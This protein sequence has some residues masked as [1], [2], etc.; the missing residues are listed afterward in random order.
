MLDPEFRIG[1]QL[2]AGALALA[3]DYIDLLFADHVKE[4]LIGDLN[5]LNGVEVRR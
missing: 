3:T 4:A 2:S 5:P 1:S